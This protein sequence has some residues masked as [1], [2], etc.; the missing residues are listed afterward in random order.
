MEAYLTQSLG[1][2]VTLDRSVH[3]LGDLFARPVA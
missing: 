3:E 2:A 1:E